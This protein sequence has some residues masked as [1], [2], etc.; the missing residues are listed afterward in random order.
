MFKGIKELP[1]MID[2]VSG[3]YGIM[4]YGMLYASGI[5]FAVLGSSL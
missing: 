1:M 3:H 5:M 4:P 2:F